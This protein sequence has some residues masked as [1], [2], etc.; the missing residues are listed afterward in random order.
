MKPIIAVTTDAV[1]GA[2]PAINMNAADM[3]PNE[4]KNAIV[5]AGGIP[6]ILPYPDDAT[7]A[8][9]VAQAVLPLFDGLILPGGPDV[10]PPNYGEEPIAQIQ[11]TAYHND[12]FQ[13]ALIRAAVAAGKPILGICRGLQI[14]N[15]A[16][17]GTLYQDL[18]TTN[19]DAYIA[20]HQLAYGG[21]PTHH[22]MTETAS[23]IHRLVGARQFVNSRHHQSVRQVAPTM[24]VSARAAD[25]V[26]EAIESREGNQLLAVQWHPENLWRQFPVQFKL[27]EDLVARAQH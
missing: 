2:H 18:A 15:V 23:H 17:G 1:L 25:A 9:E 13:I 20:H 22:V 27:F 19:P 16:M 5:A 6:I 4:I 3:A 8:E 7:F 24:Q 10:S 21:Y 26:V 14:L 12:A 11:D